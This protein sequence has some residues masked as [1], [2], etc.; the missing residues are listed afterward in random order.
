MRVI[1]CVIVL[2]AALVLASPAM[3]KKYIDDDGGII[4]VSGEIQYTDLK[5]NP[6]GPKMKVEPQAVTIDGQPG[7]PL[8]GPLEARQLR[9]SATGSGC[10]NG[11]A[12]IKRTL[13][14][15]FFWQFWHY[16]HFCY[17]YPNV[18]SVSRTW[19]GRAGSGWAYLGMLGS[20]PATFFRWCCLSDRSGHRRMFRGG[21]HWNF[22]LVGQASY[23]YPE[24]RLEAHGNGTFYY[25]AKY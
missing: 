22:P 3:A 6:K 14:G 23:N 15:V 7:V 17:V 1:Q 20:T 5:G 24:I 8:E 2:I 11:N 12:S 13:L 25:F 9:H 21:F 19:D 18:T 10:I 16:I 4:E